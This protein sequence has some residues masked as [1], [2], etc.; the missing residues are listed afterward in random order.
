MKQNIETERKR[1]ET[2]R[3]QIEIERMRLQKCEMKRNSEIKN[4]KQEFEKQLERNRELMEKERREMD[5]QRE[6]MKCETM[7]LERLRDKI[8]QNKRKMERN[9]VLMMRKEV[10][11]KTEK[12]RQERENR[13]NVLWTLNIKQQKLK[14]Q[15]QLMENEWKEQQKQYELRMI[16]YEERKKAYDVYLKQ[17]EAIRDAQ[18]F[19]EEENRMQKQNELIQLIHSPKQINVVIDHTINRSKSRQSINTDECWSEYSSSQYD[20]DSVDTAPI[21][22]QSQVFLSEKIT[23]MDGVLLKKM[24]GKLDTLLGRPAPLPNTV[25]HVDNVMNRMECADTKNKKIQCKLDHKKVYGNEEEKYEI[26]R[27]KIKM[28]DDEVQVPS[29][30]DIDWSV[31]LDMQRNGANDDVL[32]SLEHT[33]ELQSQP[34]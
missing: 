34:N 25:S 30:D 24:N 3:M 17:K 18:R 6:T 19:K 7:E 28:Y 26:E 5:K 9:K 12:H 4:A 8:Q 32:R 22:Q 23:Q 16:E 10:E 11:I 13:D 21:V 29:D 14:R 1:I 2:E 15:R 31:L 27:T 33:S 20:T